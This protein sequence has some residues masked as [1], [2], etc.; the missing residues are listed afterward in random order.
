MAFD[1]L[2]DLGKKAQAVAAVAADKAKDAAELAKINMSIASEQREIDKNFRAIGEW[3]VSEFSGEIPPAVKD[4]VDAVSAAKAK[5]AELE[6]SK[7]VKEEASEAAQSANKAC[8][9]CGTSS[10]SKFCPQCGAPMGE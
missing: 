4:L 5:I 3:Y 2:N 6:A 8:P 10:D 1:F 9:I 7:P